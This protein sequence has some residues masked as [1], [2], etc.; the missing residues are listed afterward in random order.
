MS[1]PLASLLLPL[2]AYVARGS[3]LKSKSHNTL[4]AP[5]TQTESQHSLNGPH[6]WPPHYFSDLISSPFFM[7]VSLQTHWVSGML[8]PRVLTQVVP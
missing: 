2:P 8:R 3:L 6:D 1:S 4:S 7:F 5:P